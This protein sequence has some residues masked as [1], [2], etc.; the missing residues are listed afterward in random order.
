MTLVRLTRDVID[1]QRVIAAVES[2]D[3]GAVFLFLGT[4]RDHNEGSS[5]RGIEYSA[6]EQMAEQE[7]NRIAGEAA[8]QFRVERIAVEHRLG[9]LGVG[10]VSVAV[11]V[12]HEHRS[13]AL[14]AGRYMIEELKK[15]VPIWKKELYADGRREWVDPTRAHA[16]TNP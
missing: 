1:P 5:V 3:C 16:E 12:A 14:D 7:L 8:A 9:E 4:V 6:Y 11:A 10:D 13:P 15:R 2:D